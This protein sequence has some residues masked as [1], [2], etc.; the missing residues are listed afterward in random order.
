[1]VARATPAD[2]VGKQLD[3]RIAVTPEF[4]TL[5]IPAAVTLVC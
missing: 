4:G 3:G 1:M 2:D 5:G